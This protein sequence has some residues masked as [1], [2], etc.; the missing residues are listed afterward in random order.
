MALTTAQQAKLDA[1]NIR[2]EEAKKQWA[3]WIN[4]WN[5]NFVNL[6]CYTDVKYDV[7]AAAQWFTP[8]DVSCKNVS[9]GCTKEYCKSQVDLIRN[10]MGTLRN[11]YT[12]FNSAQANYDK[13][14]SEIKSEVQSD[15]EIIK[16]LAEIEASAQA[17]RLKWIF[18]IVIVVILGIVIFVYFKWF[19]K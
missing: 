13:V 10:N 1:A 15:P 14:L 18:G 19:K 8:T 6:Q 2:N 4:F 7:Y 3:A 5:I 12:E 11:A 17:I 16:D 9:G